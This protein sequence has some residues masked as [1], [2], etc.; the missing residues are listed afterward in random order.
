LNRPAP[1]TPCD[2]FRWA[3]ALALVAVLAFA[4]GGAGL[5]HRVLVHDHAGHADH[6]EHVHAHADAPCGFNPAQ[7]P[8]ETPEQE[9]APHDCQ[10]C[11]LLA[12]GTTP[13]TVPD[14]A[15]A[16][17]R[18]PHRLHPVVFTTPDAAPAALPPARGPP[19]QSV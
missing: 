18:V 15:P 8:V 9:N 17:L 11:T 19:S 2:T 4:T 1:R 16:L 13:P 14:A 7:A 12:A 6:T 5:A 10:I 3:T